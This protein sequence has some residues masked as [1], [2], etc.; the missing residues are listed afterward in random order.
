MD[1]DAQNHVQSTM[2]EELS[3]KNQELDTKSE[4]VKSGLFRRTLSRIPAI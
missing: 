2:E 4:Y 3:D 1:L